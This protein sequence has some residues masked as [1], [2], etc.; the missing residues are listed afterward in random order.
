MDEEVS[1]TNDEK[2]AVY[3]LFNH[4]FTRPTPTEHLVNSLAQHC[5]NWKHFNRQILFVKETQQGE[6]YIKQN[7]NDSKE[8]IPIGRI[9][10]GTSSVNFKMRYL[11]VMV[12][13]TIVFWE[14][15]FQCPLQSL[16][17][18]RTSLAMNH[19]DGPLGSEIM[20]ALILHGQF[21]Y[22]NTLVR[23]SALAQLRNGLPGD[24]CIMLWRWFADSRGY[25]LDVLVS[26]VAEY[27]GDDVAVYFGNDPLSSFLFA[28]M[29]EVSLSQ[30][31]LPHGGSSD[32]HLI[33]SLV[34]HCT[35]WK[36]FNRQTLFLKTVT[37]GSRVV[38]FL[39]QN[40]HESKESGGLSVISISNLEIEINAHGLSSIGMNLPAD[41]TPRVISDGL[42]Q[43]RV[44][45]AMNYRDG[46]LTS[47][48]AKALILHWHCRHKET[49]EHNF[50]TEMKSALAQLRNGLPGDR[51]VMLW[52]WFADSRGYL[53]DV[54][55]S[56]VAE[57]LGDD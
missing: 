48:L 44:S 45:L 22:G 55:V 34:R 23:E 19:R 5:S 15:G 24:R 31:P 16:S 13:G 38:L 7:S 8:V 21:M 30:C 32:E 6:Y 53:L 4:P 26:I 46:P 36:Y 57:Y 52:R 43:L 56:I 25:L 18:L 33:D 47:E 49:A 42:P 14:G 28:Q 40:R 37:S 54:L 51:R 27:L 10:V 9:R 35:N 3:W 11:W 12:C 39:K 1:L 29:D 41:I 50:M 17:P 20:K 2:A